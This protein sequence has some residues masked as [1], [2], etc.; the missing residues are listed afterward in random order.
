MT[1]ITVDKSALPTHLRE[2]LKRRQ[3]DYE[4]KQII[5]Q[6][7][8][9]Y[10]EWIQ[11]WKL[12][13]SIHGHG[14]GIMSYQKNFFL[15]SLFGKYYTGPTK[16]ATDRLQGVYE[17]L[18]DFLRSMGGIGIQFQ[19]LLIYQSQDT[20][21]GF[22]LFLHFTEHAKKS[23]LATFILYSM[24]YLIADRYTMITTTPRT[25]MLAYEDIPYE[26]KIND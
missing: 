1:Q 9:R 13:P 22:D 26:E 19:L 21:R 25:L 16:A 11:E 8:T 7:D 2:D 24:Q 18:N 20:I 14:E 12:M 10:D 15:T 3:Y 17:H 5:S 6:V 4:V 23:E